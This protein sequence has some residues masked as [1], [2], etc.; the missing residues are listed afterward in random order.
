MLRWWLLTVLCLAKNTHQAAHSH[1]QRKLGE[2]ES[3]GAFSPRDAHHVSD[4]EHDHA[5]D[6]EAILGSRREAEEFDELSPEE[7]KKRLLVLLS[8]MD[9]NLDKN[10]DSW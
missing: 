1:G 9:R 5:F 8:K 10:I 3:D 2:R 7:S 6:H 4:G